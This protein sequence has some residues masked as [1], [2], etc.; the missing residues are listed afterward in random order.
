MK[1]TRI[2]MGMPI[3]VEIL[4][5]PSAE[6]FNEVFQFFKYIDQKFSTYKTTSE[7][8]LIN[9][10]KLKKKDFSKDMKII[11]KLAAKTKRDTDGFFNIYHNGKIDPSGVVK[12]W[13]IHQ[14]ALILKK[15][16]YKSF[17]VNAGGDIEV[18][19]K[20][21]GKLW[22]IGIKNPFNENEIIKVIQLKQGGIATSGNYIRGP[23]IYDPKRN[24]KL[25]DLVSLTIIGPNIYEAD[26]FA[27]AAFAM[28]NQ[29]INFIEK[30]NGFEGYSID[31]NGIATLTSGFEK[32][33]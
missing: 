5:H 30:L 27:T 9:Q 32:Y 33:L 12:G 10:G 24:S 14:A 18:S 3:I 29:G 1:K 28:G 23:H 7:I 21:S 11:F 17:Y 6:I 25:D 4:D 31:K 19:G 8:S 26:R 15:R 13:A 2:I 16:G 20:K 22:K